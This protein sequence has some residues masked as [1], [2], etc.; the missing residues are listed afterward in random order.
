[1]GFDGDAEALAV[2]LIETKLLLNSIIS[3]AK[4]GTR[5]MSCDLKYF[6]L[7]APMLKLE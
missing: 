6:F 2:S 4:D 1:M 7:V 5:F 3:G